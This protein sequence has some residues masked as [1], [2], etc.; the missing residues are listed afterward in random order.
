MKVRSWQPKRQQPKLRPRKRSKTRKPQLAKAQHQTTKPP[1]KRVARLGPR[2]RRKYF[3]DRRDGF[4][5]VGFGVSRGNEKRLELAAWHVNAS[6]N[7]APE[8]L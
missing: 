7:Q 1:S 3:F 5:D 4:V 6:L 2:L 8:V